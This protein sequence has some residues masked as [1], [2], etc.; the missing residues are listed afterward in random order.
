MAEIASTSAGRN[1]ADTRPGRDAS[2]LNLS[3]AA[4]ESDRRQRRVFAAANRESNPSALFSAG[5]LGI[6]VG[7]AA[8]LG[9]LFVG[10]Q[11]IVTADGKPVVCDFLAFW[12]A[13]F[14]ALSGHAAS[15]YDPNAFHAVQAGIAGPFPS[16]LYWNYPPVFLFVAVVLASMPYLPAFLGWAVATATGYA[17]TIGVIV[18]RWEGALAACASP[19]VLLSVF[20]GQNGFLT[21]AL[22]GGFLRFLPGRPIVGGVLLGLVTYK[23]QFGI[24]VPV[25]LVAGGYW[26]SFLSAFATAVVVAGVAALVF[27]PGI[28]VDFFR[29]LPMV[30]HSNLDAGGE[31][32]AKIQSVYAIDRMLGAGNSLAWLVQAT[33]T[34]GCALATFVIWRRDVAYEL[35]AASLVTA[36]MFSIPYLHVYDFPVLLVAMA[37]LYRHRSF[38]RVE[39]SCIIMANLFLLAFLA[40]IAPV[41]PVIVVMVAALI[42]RRTIQ[43]EGVVAKTPTQSGVPRPGEASPHPV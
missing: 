26:R 7:Y 11:W 18:R 43:Q 1:A 5:M 40:Q 41:G 38:D 28:Y 3:P 19:V 4:V 23:P 29:S 9:F 13:G 25:A 21:A 22:I 39:W 2:F 6:L 31:G 10:H 8:S 14:T 12:A 27:G 33:V 16:Y 30:A 42:L 36:T 15:V 17:I 24:L 32:W 20:G 35:K 34:L 37:F